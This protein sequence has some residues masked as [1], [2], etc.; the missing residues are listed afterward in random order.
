[1]A[2]GSPEALPSERAPGQPQT[3]TQPREFGPAIFKR[4]EHWS[5]Y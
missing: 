4:L 5:G 2:L 1:M 3:A